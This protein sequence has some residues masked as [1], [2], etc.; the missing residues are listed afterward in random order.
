MK[1]ARQLLTSIKVDNVTD[2]ASDVHVFQAIKLAPSYILQTFVYASV[3]ITAIHI[4]NVF[5]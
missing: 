4:A 1:I 5:H 3:V 2:T